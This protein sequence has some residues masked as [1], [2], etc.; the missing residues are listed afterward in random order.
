LRFL[1][2]TG[3]S[4]GIKLQGAAKLLRAPLWSRMLQFRRSLAFPAVLVFALAP[5]RVEARSLEDVEKSGTVAV[6]LRSKHGKC[7][8]I[9]E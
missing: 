7:S 8:H 6:R 2:E 4:C 1:R 5:K 3:F 9:L